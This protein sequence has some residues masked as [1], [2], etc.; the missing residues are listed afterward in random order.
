MPPGLPGVVTRHVDG[1]TLR[2]DGVPV[3]LIGIDAPETVRPGSPV[4]CFG[5]EASAALARLLPLGT[6]VHLVPD[7]SA[8]DRYGRR[9]AYVYRAGDGLFVNLELVRSGFAT[10]YTVPPDVARAPDLL[11]AE[12]AARAAGAGLWGGCP[13]GPAAGAPPTGGAAPPGGSATPY[14]RN[15][16]AARAAGVA[17]ILRGQPG[18]RSGLDRDGDGVACE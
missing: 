9:L 2:V 1:D 7:V 10:V 3:R 16:A 4:A 8:Q 12:R 5:P 11:A 18:Y 13:A 6:R 17:P 14:Y 15:C